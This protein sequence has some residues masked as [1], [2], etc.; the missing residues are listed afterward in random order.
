MKIEAKKSL[1]QN[2]LKDRNILQIMINAGEVKSSDTVIEIGP[3]TGNLTKEIL[4]T[5]A[6]VIAIEKDSRLIEK[7]NLEF[8]KEILAGKFKLIEGDILEIDVAEILKYTS[9]ENNSMNEGVSG[10]MSNRDD[11]KLIANIPYYITGQIL[12]KFTSSNV[13]PST[14]VLMV[15]K[16]VARRIVDSK[17]SILS[18][19]IKAYG[20]P[21]LEKVVKAGSFVPAPNV[22]SAIISIKSIS[23]TNFRDEKHEKIFF[24]VIKTAFS[25]KRKKAIS[26][27]K[28]IF[29]AD[30]LNNI[31]KELQIDENTRSEE[32]P[33]EKWLKISFQ[34]EYYQAY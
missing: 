1:G 6:R 20:K 31:W 9:K 27:L 13:P 30:T 14:C 34:L 5:G 19:S 29:N 25:H 28:E 3:G 22:D 16:E 24:T 18:L 33:L 11:Y 17:E 8:Q 12:E 15:Q 26:N 23:K 7:L 21:R 32:I 4:A 2:F 10:S